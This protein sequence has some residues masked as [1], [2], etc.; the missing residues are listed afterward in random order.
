MSIGIYLIENTTT[1]Q[2][3][4][5]SST[6]IASRWRCH[7]H[8]L[9]EGKHH[10][11]YLQNSYNKYG[12]EA[13]SYSILEKCSADVL[14]EREKFWMA[15]KQSLR[16]QNGYNLSTET[17]A[18]RR[19]YKM[20]E[21]EKLAVRTNPKLK[22]HWVRQQKKVIAIPLKDDLNPVAIHF[23]SLIEAGIFFGG[24]RAKNRVCD[25]LNGR[26]PY[27]WGYTFSYASDTL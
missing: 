2:T 8:D 1:G 14:V 21:E 15:E 22:E 23:D 17:D 3:Y 6:D 13:F 5:G 19:G 16:C 11:A 4:V 7:K 10:N 20:T 25:C 9:R 26:R 27:A 24:G 12:S 18:P